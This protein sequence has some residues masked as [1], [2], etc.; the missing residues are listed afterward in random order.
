[1]IRSTSRPAI[2]PASLV[3]W[4]WL[5]LKYAGTVITAWLTVSPRN[6]SAVSFILPSTKALIWL[7]EYFSPLASTQASP[8]SPRAMVYG[9]I[10]LS[11]AT[12][13]SS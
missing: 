11:L 13:G 6:A 3:A 8:L 2:R 9:T 7:G 4:R 5:S 1:M 10:S 12:I